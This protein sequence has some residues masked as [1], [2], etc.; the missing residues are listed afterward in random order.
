[1]VKHIT[2]INNQH[3]CIVDNCPTQ[4]HGGCTAWTGLNDLD[5]EGQYMWDHSNTPVVFANWHTNE[6]SLRNSSY[7]L[8]RDCIDMFRN[9]KWNDRPCSYYNQ[10]ICKKT[11]KQN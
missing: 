9:G 7:A 11:K 2:Y 1:M 4:L 6:P 3:Y 8:T 5:I 10:F